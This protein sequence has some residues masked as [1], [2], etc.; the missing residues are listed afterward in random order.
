MEQ[1]LHLLTGAYAL[2][3]VTDEERAAFEESALTDPQIREEVREL[4]ETAALLAYGAAPETPPA[5][6]KANVL[7][8]I[9][10]TGQQPATAVADLSEARARRQDQG[11]RV[12]AERRP[13]NRDPRARTW[14]RTLGAAAAVL[15]V[16][17]G[18][19][20]GWALGQN[21]TNKQLEQQ[22]SAAQS[23]QQAML[24]IMS[25]PD[26]KMSTATAS[27]G[28]TVTVASSSAADRAAV[29]VRDLPAP[30]AGKAYELWF[31]SAS[32][33]VPA[34]M[35]PGGAETSP[36]M[37]VLHGNMDGAT[38]VGITVEP[39]SGSAKPTTDPIVV[40]KL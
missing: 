9:R 7:A 34:G 1:Q 30:P 37:T 13:R 35:L 3:A 14:I 28:A 24:A 19:I 22:L 20:G 39:A 38:H 4:G 32:G 18:G 36:A 8:A 23:R 40:Q 25:S 21:A 15:L 27:N 2:D 16:A 29:M 31:I 6:L 12:R 33:A 17:V 5:A 26:A 11:P 10:A